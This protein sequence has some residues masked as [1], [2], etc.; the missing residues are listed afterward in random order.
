M[1]TKKYAFFYLYTFLAFYLSFLYIYLD[2]CPF[3][4]FQFQLVIQ[5]RF[6]TSIDNTLPEAFVRVYVVTKAKIIFHVG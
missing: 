6:P 1:N 3:S 4:Y 5:E 2:F